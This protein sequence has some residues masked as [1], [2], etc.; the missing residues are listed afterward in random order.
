ML[1][2]TKRPDHKRNITAIDTK[3]GRT[4]QDRTGTYHSLHSYQIVS[5]NEGNGIN[6]KPDSHY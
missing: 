4:G 5:I 6:R 3:A 2:W 1:G